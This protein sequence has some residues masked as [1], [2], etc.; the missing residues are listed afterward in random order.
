MPISNKQQTMQHFANKHKRTPCT[1]ITTV[2]K[3]MSIQFQANRSSLLC[4]MFDVLRW[5]L[6]SRVSKYRDFNYQ[7][8]QK[9]EHHDPANLQDL[10]NTQLNQ[11][12][13]GMILFLSSRKQRR[14]NEFIKATRRRPRIQPPSAP[15]VLA[16]RR[17]WCVAASIFV[18][19][20]KHF[21]YI[22]FPIFVDDGGSNG[23]SPNMIFPYRLLQVIGQTQQ[24]L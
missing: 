5:I 6:L 4:K 15:P 10:R 16:H 23:L 3:K 20:S 19:Y 22:R 9:S 1:Q 8:A 18:A 17:P 7:S 21:G 12:F 13:C 11:S 24:T 14:R 2:K